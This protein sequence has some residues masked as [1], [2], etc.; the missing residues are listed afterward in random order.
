MQTVF[1][2]EWIL[3]QPEQTHQP[4]EACHVDGFESFEAC[5]VGYNRIVLIGHMKSRE[6]AM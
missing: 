2:R 4:D 1:E 5:D 3:T 6:S